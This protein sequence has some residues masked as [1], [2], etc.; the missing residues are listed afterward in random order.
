MQIQVNVKQL[1]K[2]KPAVATQALEIA[3]LK[4]NTLKELITNIVKQQV[5]AFNKRTESSAIIPFLT[6]SDIETLS[7]SGKIGFGSVHNPEKAVEEKAVENALLAFKD[8]L[9]CVF[10]DEK[11]LENL[12]EKINPN[13]ESIFTFVR[14]TFLSGR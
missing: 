11:P 8:G 4:E 2:K 3:D 5:T 7:H 9:F 1:G 12:S 10:M 14:L 6:N 13:P